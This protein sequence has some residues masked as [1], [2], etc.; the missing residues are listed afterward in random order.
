MINMSECFALCG[1]DGC[2]D[3]ASSLGMQG[4]NKDLGSFSIPIYEVFYLKILIGNDS[5]FM[6]DSIPEVTAIRRMNNACGSVTVTINLL[7]MD[8]LTLL[9]ALLI[10]TPNT[11][12]N[13][14]IKL[15]AVDLIDEILDLLPMLA[16]LAGMPIPDE[17]MDAALAGSTMQIEFANRVLEVLF[18]KLVDILNEDM[19]TKGIEV[20][21]WEELPEF[22]QGLLDSGE[23]KNMLQL[24]RELGALG[25]TL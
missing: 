7:D 24:R 5:A 4:V 17:I 10:F 15:N 18:D 1:T 16:D 12:M 23:M 19:S 6:C 14:F 13:C 9:G 20:R 11:G 3:V 22:Y 21:H 2:M 8:I 25:F